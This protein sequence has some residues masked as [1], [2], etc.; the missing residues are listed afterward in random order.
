[1]QLVLPTL[2]IAA[3][4]LLAPAVL[5]LFSKRTLV[6]VAQGV[7]ELEKASPILQNKCADCHTPG[8]SS[9]PLYASL[10]GVHEYLDTDIR[11]AQKSFLLTQDQ[12]TGR[13]SIARK[14]LASIQTV[15]ETGDMP[16]LRYKLLH[17]NSSLSDEEKE[18]ISSWIRAAANNKEKPE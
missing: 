14:D 17:W 16:P 18:S 3:V 8:L 10:P 9:S 12:L 11:E 4:L 1:M 15:I 2:A 13:D 5:N 6:P 7:E